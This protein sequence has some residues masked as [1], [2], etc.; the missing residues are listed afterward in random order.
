MPRLW[1][2]GLAAGLGGRSCDRPPNG[3]PQLLLPLKRVWRLALGVESDIRTAFAARL[4]GMGYPVAWENI[5]FMPPDAIWLEAQLFRSGIDRLT[6]DGAHRR[7]GIFQV[8]VMAPM[9]KGAF[10]ADAVAEAVQAQFP[11]DMKFG[12]ARVTQMPEIAG[13]Y[14]DGS[15][16]RVPVSVNFEALG[17]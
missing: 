13:G 7:Y 1:N 10:P 14:P 3:G 15:F 2:M 8:A 5:D 4:D 12:P 17:L 6:T 9:G 16:W 11:C